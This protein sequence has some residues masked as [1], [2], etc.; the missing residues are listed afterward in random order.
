MSIQENSDRKDRGDGRDAKGRWI[1]SGN[2]KGRPRR[3]VART[4]NMEDPYYFSQEEMP[5]TVNGETVY[6][7]R[8]ELVMLKLFDSAMKGRITAQ[9]HLYKIF[10]E[11]SD[12]RQNTYIQLQTWFDILES[13]PKS[14][15]D[16]MLK[17]IDRAA[18]MM[19]QEQAMLDEMRRKA[20]KMRRK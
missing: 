9:K 7:T 18:A 1:R 8:N 17:F 5:V 20:A 3:Q 10:K 16:E 12:A 6:K 13:D 11:E 4:L 14:V 2:P 19:E 15:S